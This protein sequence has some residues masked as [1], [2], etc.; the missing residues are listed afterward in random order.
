MIQLAQRDF[1]ESEAEILASI[2]NK[3]SQGFD[4]LDD[5]NYNKLSLREKYCYIG[6]ISGANAMLEIMINENNDIEE[7]ILNKIQK[8]ISKIEESEESEESEEAIEEA[9]KE[10][11]EEANKEESEEELI[12][13]E[14]K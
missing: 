10:E 2:I 6:L 12:E 5:K 9:N 14:E 8:K 3:I 7:I 1:L 11:S 4:F 13:I